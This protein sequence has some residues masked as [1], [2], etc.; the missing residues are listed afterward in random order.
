MKVQITKKTIADFVF[1]LILCAAWFL[2]GW[3]VQSRRSPNPEVALIEQVREQLLS[4]YPGEVP[5]SRE[6]TYAAIRGM[7]RHVGD[8]QAALLEP[9]VS[10]RF[11]DDFGGR[12]GV[13]G[14]FPERQDGEMVVSVVF[15]GEPAEQAGL[16]VGDVILSVDGVEFDAETSSTEAALLIRGPVGVPAHFVVRRGEGILELDP[17]RQERTIVEAQMLDGG[18][19][20][21]K[22]YTFT[23]NAPQKVREALQKLL[24]QRPRGLIWD[25]RSNGGGSMQAAQEVLSC[26]IEEG[27]LFVAE[28]KG[29]EQR[30]FVASGDGVA[31]EVP[32][33]VL[34]GERT[35]SSAETAAVAIRERQRGTLIGGTTYGKGTIQKTEPL[36]ED[37]MLQLTIARWLSPAG[38]WYGG[39]GVAPDIVV[40][41]DE[42]TDEDEVLQFALDYIEQKIE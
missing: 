24:A 10:Q 16:Q 41:D 34:I 35:Y 27:L 38:E 39:R 36:I 40:N 4:E 37:C 30:P 32:L 23:A 31:T 29:G 6:L 5:A 3:T 7:L 42:S 28:L 21:L 33:L 11:W 26:F 25:L 13:I 8:P 15:P 14:L 2:I 12:S 22:Q 1:L 19:A 9:V 18:I 17:V 20:Y